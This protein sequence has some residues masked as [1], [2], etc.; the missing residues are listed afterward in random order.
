[1]IKGIKFATIPTRDQDRALAFYTEKL[2]FSVITDQPFNDQQRWIEL[3]I[4]GHDTGIVLFTAPGHEDLIGR[5]QPITFFST[6]VRRT[7]DELVSRG[8]AF[9]APPVVADWGSS[10]IFR[11]EDGNRFVLSSK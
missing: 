2:G 10:A 11:D 4:R 3:R 6:D 5:D 7:Y 8:V 1:M 9:D